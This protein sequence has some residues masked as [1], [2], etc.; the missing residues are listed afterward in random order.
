MAYRIERHEPLESAV[1]RIARDQLDKARDELGDDDLGRHEQV[2]QLRKRFKKVRALLRLVHDALGDR[3]GEENAWF[4]D[5]ARTVSDLRDAHALVETCQE[6]REAALD[7]EDGDA[8][9]ALGEL[10]A[11][12]QGRRDVLARQ[13]D[14]DGRLARLRHQ[15]SAAERRVGAWSL[16]EDGL[17]AIQEGLRRTYDRARDALEEVREAPDTARLHELRKRAKYHRYHLRLLRELWPA[18][19]NVLRE[20][21]HDLTDALGDDHDLAVLL[22]TL[23]A[24][25][26]LVPEDGWEAVEERIAERRR[27]HQARARALAERFFAEKGKDVERRVAG[28]WRAWAAAPGGVELQEA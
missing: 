1:K 15:L 10:E 9:A 27:A 3:Y 22:E 13:L 20:E 24:E 5:E 25:P 19:V 21:A 11:D 17:E 7:D 4:R 8:A 12:L 26:D 6:L 16:E 14:L 28:W 2:H 23:G 18:V